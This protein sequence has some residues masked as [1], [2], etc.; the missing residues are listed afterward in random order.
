MNYDDDDERDVDEDEDVDED[1][2]EGVDEDVDDTWSASDPLG[3]TGLGQLAA[4]LVVGVVVTLLGVLV[5]S[6]LISGGAEQPGAS[7]GAARITST[8]WVAGD[9]AAPG[10]DHEGHGSTRLARCASG[11]QRLRAP[12]DAAQA[13]LDQWSVHVGAMNKLVVGEITLKQATDFWNDTRVGARQRLEELDRAVDDLRREGVD[14][15]D[16]GLLAPGNVAL[17]SCARA[18]RAEVVALRAAQVSTATWAEHVHHMDMLRLGQITPEQATR[19]W[20]ASWQ[21]GVREL[22]DYKVAVRAAQHQDG[23][24]GAA[25]TR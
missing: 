16:P 23:C 24:A 14:C 10:A 5:W 1:V 9:A 11:Y 3:G 2:D 8:G 25:A 21:Q 18:V 6:Q 12:L 4:A 13:S 22:D 15:P 7:A 17:P 19:M 20:L